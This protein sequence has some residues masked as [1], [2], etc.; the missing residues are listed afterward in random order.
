MII[1]SRSASIFPPLLSIT[2]LPLVWLLTV[3]MSPAL[4]CPSLLSVL[5]I[6]RPAEPVSALIFPWFVSPAALISI[7]A[8]FNT[9]LLPLL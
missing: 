8:A 7:V 2:A 6:C 5:S 9:L 1:L 4:I 3:S